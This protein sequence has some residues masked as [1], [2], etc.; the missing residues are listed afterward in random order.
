[1]IREVELPR[2]ELV[3]RAAA[4]VTE[5]GPDALAG[6]AFRTC[7]WG[8]LL[9]MRDGL[10][11]D[12]ETF[13]LAALLH[14][15]ALARRDDRVGCFAADGAKQ[16]VSLLEEWNVA[17]PLRRRIGDAICL[18][19]RIAVPPDLGVEAHLVHDGAG[20]D[21]V[22]R[23]LSEVEPELRRRVLERYPR[24]D[25][26]GFLAD[27]FVQEAEKHPES[28]MGLWVSSGFVDRIRRAPFE[29]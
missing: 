6:H 3:E 16:A 28:R 12:K 19:V 10:S 27:F 9:G 17:E 1:M 23:R 26:K 13:A 22:G 7:D 29:G 2:T 11:W 20:L 5:V 8:S 18:H 15:L 24:G 4:L 14:D 25:L 21:V